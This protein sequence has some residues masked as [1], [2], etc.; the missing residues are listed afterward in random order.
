MSADLMY[1]A[2]SAAL[3]AVMWIPY[4]LARIQSWGLVNAVGYP[5][6]PPAVPKWAE[7]AQRAH[8][9]MVENL[10]PLAALILV[11]RELG[12]DPTTMAWGAALFFW[13]RIVHWIVFIAGI[14]WVRTVAFALAWLGI[15]I[16]FFGVLGAEGVGAA[17]G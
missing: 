8:L 7:R 14:P 12:A 3:C 17:S 10:I 6:N 1:L 16:A 11:G 4:I 5:E 13:A 15:A 2:L 9:N